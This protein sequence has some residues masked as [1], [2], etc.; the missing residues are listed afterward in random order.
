MRFE[1]RAYRSSHNQ[2]AEN[3]VGRDCR[4]LSEY[5][6]AD[7][8]MRCSEYRVNIYVVNSLLE[9]RGLIHDNS[10]NACHVSKITLFSIDEYNHRAGW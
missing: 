9:S 10:P 1:V 8:F 3:T 4:L 5:R 2:R 6:G 7:R